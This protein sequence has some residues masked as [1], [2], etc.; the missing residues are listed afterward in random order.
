[1]PIAPKKKPQKSESPKTEVKKF[2][3]DEK[4]APTVE[5]VDRELR[6]LRAQLGMVCRQMELLTWRIASKG[7]SKTNAIFDPNDDIPF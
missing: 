7:I 1:M 2:L 5:E 4:S 6:H 3:G